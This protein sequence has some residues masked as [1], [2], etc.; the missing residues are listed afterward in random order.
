MQII[1][2]E[3]WDRGEDAGVDE[4]I[5][6]PP[7]L[8]YLVGLGICLGLGAA[9]LAFVVRYGLLWLP[10]VALCFLAALALATRYAAG[11]V[12]LR[13]SALALRRGALTIR[14]VTLPVWDAWPEVAQGPL[15][16]LLDCGRVTFRVGGSQVTVRVRQVRALLRLLA[17]RRARLLGAADERALLRMGRR[18][19]IEA[20]EV[21]SP[22]GDRDVVGG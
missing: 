7:P 13:G 22:A 18:A 17:E 12:A 21:N 10:G 14:E 20:G 8:G 1:R 2:R 19:V 11:S 15:G 16:R 9:C 5:F 4:V 3:R 6:Y